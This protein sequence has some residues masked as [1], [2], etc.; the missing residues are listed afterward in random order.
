M[1]VEAIAGMRRTAKPARR[2]HARRPSLALVA[3]RWSAAA[4]AEL[5]RS[6]RSRITYGNLI[7]AMILVLAAAL[8]VWLGIETDRLGYE[9]SRARVLHEQ[10][11]RDVQALRAEYATATTPAELERM[12][13]ERL[14]M[15]PPAPG[16]L[17]VLK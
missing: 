14:G 13:R 7:A 5:G 4:G 1:S 12:A 2:R 11:A 10:L 3:Q 6:I 16:Q 17:V 8:H 9:L 15:A